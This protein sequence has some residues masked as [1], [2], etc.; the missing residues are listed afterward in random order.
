MFS[1]TDALVIFAILGFA[2][3][4]LSL[5]SVGGEGKTQQVSDCA[6]QPLVDIE[7]REKGASVDV[8]CDTPDL[9]ARLWGWLTGTG[10]SAGQR[11]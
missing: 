8:P 9:I 4:I 5:V 6:N 11:T 10:K 7:I 2:A 3:F 1:K